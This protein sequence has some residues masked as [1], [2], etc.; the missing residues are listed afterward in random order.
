MQQRHTESKNL[1]RPVA[2]TAPRKLG[3]KTET[4]PEK[5]SKPI[6][7]VLKMPQA[8]SAAVAGSFNNWDQKHSPMARDGNG[9]WKATIALAP[10]RYEYR[11][12]ID[13]SQWLSDPAA[14]E[15]VRN[16]FGTTNSVV[17]I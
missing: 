6:E 2:T 15:S 13:G 16:D 5:N 8:H 14:K 12:V 7:F 10:G 9:G 1:V 3:R 4:Q 11:F 17:V